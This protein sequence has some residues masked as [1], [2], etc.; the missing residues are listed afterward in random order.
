MFYPI[1]S[2][3]ASGDPYFTDYV[4]L[5]L[6]M[7][8]SDN[9]TSF[10]DSSPDTRTITRAGATL[11]VTKTGVK[12]YGTASAYFASNTSGQSASRLRCALPAIG[13]NPFTIEGWVYTVSNATTFHIFGNNSD[14]SFTSSISS[15][16][17]FFLYYAPA[18]NS[19]RV[20]YGSPTAYLDGSTQLSNNT[21]YHF[22][23]TR[24]ESNVV[25][26][27]VDGQQEVSAT[28][29]ND[30]SNV[31]CVIGGLIS[32]SAT[33][34]RYLDD[35]RLTIGVCRYPENFTAPTEAY[36]TSGTAAIQ[37]PASPIVA[38]SDASRLITR[39]G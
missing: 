13:T 31:Y 24:D 16:A 11:P 5:L 18:T 19:I 7:N 20:A 14:S 37:F 9:G 1:P 4:E 12:K 35:L 32:T 36:P 22:A 2:V 6:P 29:S 21:W 17:T 10:P 23:L 34:N 27:F 8:G 15:E 25:R 28:I 3:A 39:V 26:I 33:P 30:F 38:V